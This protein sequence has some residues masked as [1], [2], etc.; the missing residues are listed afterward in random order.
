MTRTLMAL[1]GA[2]LLTFAGPTLRAAEFEDGVHYTK[3][4]KPQPVQTGDKIE[5]LEMFWYGC[6]HCYDLEPHLKKWLKNI[7]ENAEYVM[8][9][10]VFRKSWEPHAR[11]FY[12]FE[13]LGIVDKMHEGFFDAIHKERREFTNAE[14]VAAWAGETGTDGD[15]IK[16]AFN[17]FAVDTKIQQAMASLAGY[18]A[19]G[20]PTVIIDGKYSTSVS[21]T[22]GYDQLFQV[23]EFLINKA[24]SER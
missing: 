11:A 12:S 4:S 9:P 18:Q 1:V 7:P 3:L 24:A 10:A 16:E 2:A 5:V 23:I 19:T 14:E 6:P 13:A 22:G 8:L 21:Q 15:K 17:S 20:V